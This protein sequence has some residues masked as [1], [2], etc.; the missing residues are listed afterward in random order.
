MKNNKKIVLI[1]ARGEAVRNFLYSDL[2]NILHKS[3][4]ELTLLSV[5][6]DVEFISRYRSQFNEII[7]IEPIKEKNFI[8]TLRNVLLFAHYRW[9][10]TEKVKN[11]WE[12]LDSEQKTILKK[13][14]HL[15]WKG[16]IILFA[17]R[18]ALD[19][20]AE[21]EN[22]LTYK[23]RPTKEYEAIFK[24]IK[25]EL[26]FN[27]SHIHAPLGELPVRIAQK[28]GIMTATFVFSWDNLTSR[29]RILPQYDHVFVWNLQ[30]KDEF[31]RYYPAFD[32][33][34]IHITG[35]PQFDF[36]F[37]NA[38]QLT[39]EELS[40]QIGLD[41]KRDFIL[42]TTGMASD[43]PEEM[44]H[45][46][47]VISVIKSVERNKRPQL[48]VRMYIKGTSNEMVEMSKK[49][50]PDVIFPKILWEEKWFTPSFEDLFI[51]TGLIEHCL[52][53]INP[54]STV[55]LELLLK[56]KQVINLGFDPPGS[57]L[58]KGYHWIRHIRFDHY[59]KIVQTGLLTVAYSSE[60][61]KEYILKFLEEKD[62]KSLPANDFFTRNYIFHRDG[63][64]GARLASKMAEILNENR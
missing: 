14:K 61:L 36:H 8:L 18:F 48:V 64:S 7:P 49:N 12:I 51:Y 62:R 52:F 19:M 25:P 45:L 39:K 5:I 29:G 46:R 23:F 11:K 58:T 9:I 40:H 22:Q 44:G 41:P 53:G 16:L 63:Q 43:F 57:N 35:T 50:D 47:E 56:D 59:Q 33:N 4:F 6:D 27:T 55:S 13:V 10:W 28:L 17:N 54:A 3:D 26:V 15:C 38:F 1:I 2:I 31:I 42:Y 20:L 21:I 30:M 34:N 32:K 24:R 60:E 37:N